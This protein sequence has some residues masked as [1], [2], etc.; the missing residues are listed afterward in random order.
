M[1]SVEELKARSKASI[2]SRFSFKS[3]LHAAQKTR[4]LAEEADNKGDVEGAYVGYRKTVKWV[5]QI[6]G[7][8]LDAAHSTSMTCS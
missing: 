5:I 1:A 4:N 6:I 7:C 8:N 3:W 2:D